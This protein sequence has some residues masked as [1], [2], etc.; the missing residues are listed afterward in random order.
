MNTTYKNHATQ[1]KDQIKDSPVDEGAK[2]QTKCMGNIFNEI[3]LENFLN[4]YNNIDT[5]VRE[6]WNSK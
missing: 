1:S 5:L 4:L 3:I 2:I 6:D